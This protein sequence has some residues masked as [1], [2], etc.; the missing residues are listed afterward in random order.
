MLSH[1]LSRVFCVLL[2]GRTLHPLSLAASGP[3]LQTVGLLPTHCPPAMD[4][5]ALAAAY[6][7]SGF[8]YIDV[9]LLHE[10]GTFWSI[11]SLPW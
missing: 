6:A 2:A 5:P 3:Y 1:L 11:G 4:S 7:Q 10:S 8:A 9:R